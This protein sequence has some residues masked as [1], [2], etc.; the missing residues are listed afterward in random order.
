M[1][2]HVERSGGARVV[3]VDGSGA[4]A[5][6]GEFGEAVGVAAEVWDVALQIVIE[7]RLVPLPGRHHHGKRPHQ[8]LL[9]RVVREAQPAC[10]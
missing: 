3:Q 9:H 8:Q 10:R 6:A 2:T 4:Q 5:A 7:D 1:S